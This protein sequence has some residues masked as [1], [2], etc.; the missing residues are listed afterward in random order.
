MSA[1]KLIF[2]GTGAAW[3]LPEL[4]CDCVICRKMRILGER[5]S[6]TSMWFDGPASLLI[7]CGPDAAWQLENH[8]LG[9]PDGVVITHEHGDHYI[10]LDEL[11]A[12]RRIHPE[13]DFPP[14]PCY[15]H[16]DAWTTIE[17]RFGYLLGR[18]LS[19]QDAVP[20][21]SLKGLENH[22]VQVIPFK[23]DH[24]PI[25]KGSVGYAIQYDTDAGS[26][27]LVYTSDFKD[28][29]G[30]IDALNAP[31]YLVASCHWFN[32]PEHNRPSHMS[33]QRLLEFIKQWRPQ[34]HVYLVHIS[35]GDVA[36]GESS[37]A[38]LKKRKPLDPLP[39][40]VPT[41]QA[42]WQSTVEQVFHDHGIDVPVTVAW[43]GLIVDI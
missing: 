28:V 25:P 34:R 7:D 31:D 1:V 6:R 21:Q 10:G 11:D 40:K 2:L 35:D 36:Q 15:A 26:R 19:K 18:V 4:G 37:E 29:T 9:C 3:R 17:A 41:C 42:E 22:G 20:G 38:M 23:T 13:N 33:L 39:Y 27:T 30:P 8:G 14:I 5:R 16:P 24:G 43:D 12:F 32:E